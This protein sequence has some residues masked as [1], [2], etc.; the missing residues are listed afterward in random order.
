MEHIIVYVKQVEGEENE[1]LPCEIE[2]G[3]TGLPQELIE[4][5]KIVVDRDIKAHELEKNKSKGVGLD[6]E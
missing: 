4:E 2:Q 5:A 6:G 1:I 3:M